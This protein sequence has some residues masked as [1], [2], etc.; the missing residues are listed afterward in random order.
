MKGKEKMKKFVRKCF[1]AFL[2]LF[3]TLSFISTHGIMVNAVE[4]D[5][6]V[7]IAKLCDVT[8]PQNENA[9]P[10]MFDENVQTI[11]SPTTAAGW[12]ATVTFKLPA[13]NTKPVEKIEIRFRVENSSQDKWNMDVK[14]G[15]YVNSVTDE[16]V[17]K[18]VKG[19]MLKDAFVF[20]FD[21]PINISHA[22]VTMSN[23]KDGDNQAGFWPQIAEM[24]I[25]VAADG[26][27]SDLSNLASNAVI[28]SCG[29]G[30]GNAANLVDDNYSS[31]YVFYN[32]GISSIKGEAW[33]Q[34]DLGRDMDV[35]SLEIAFEKLAN[36]TNNFGFTYSI[37]GMKTTDTDWTKLVASA[38]ANRTDNSVNEHLLG[39]DGATVKYSKFKIVIE[40]ITSTGGDPWPAIAEFKIFGK[41]EAMQDPGNLA[42][43]KPTHTNTNSATSS[44]ITDGSVASSWSGAYYP[45]YVDIDL[46]GNYNISDIEV[47]LPTTGYTQY[48]IYTSMDGRD[49]TK[50]LSKVDTEST[51]VDGD[52]YKVGVEARIVRVYIN[53][54]S[55]GSNAVINEV[56]ILGEASSTP[57][58]QTPAVQVENFAD[59]KYD[60]DIT[61][62]MTIAEVQGIISRQLGVQY[63][64]WFD[65]SLG[66]NP[67]GNEY[68]YFTLSESNGKIHIEGNDGVSDR[69]SVV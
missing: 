63:I 51:P 67:N 56:R 40:S 35:A 49:F 52:R 66:T 16:L 31:L 46:E 5:E 41:E 37:Y 54:Q 21:E 62:E 15:Y 64:D 20:E 24:G 3:I 29:N 57:V 6:L 28:T 32:G 30:A 25:F 18:E 43:Q 4:E 23:P 33:V 61:D 60:V 22:M 42:W 14:L 68:D 48:D 34:A 59:S 47:Y 19:H 39:V 50:L 9:I 69:K 44:K 38:T 17:A 45:G 58:Q 13:D 65:L 10:N 1:M 8:V 55:S 27:E 2:S 36:D 53:Y 11:W 7:N 12:P 26:Q